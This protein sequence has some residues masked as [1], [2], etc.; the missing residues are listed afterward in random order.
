PQTY[1]IEQFF[2]NGTPPYPIERT[3]LTSTVLDLGLHSMKD[4]GKT[5]TGDALSIRYQA[6]VDPGNFHGRWT[7]ACGE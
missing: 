6:P 2:K 4:G 7:D 1:N 5:M 3:L